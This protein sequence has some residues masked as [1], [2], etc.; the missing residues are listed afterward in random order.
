M[1]AKFIVE[2]INDVLKPKSKEEIENEI[3]N[4][5]A[6]DMLQYGFKLQDKSLIQRALDNGAKIPNERVLYR[7][8]DRGMFSEDELK[9]YF[10]DAFKL[11]SG[12]NVKN[13][14]P[15]QLFSAAVK[16][17]EPE[18]I[19]SALRKGATNVD[20]LNY[21]AL[22]IAI[23]KN[24]VSLLRMLMKNPKIDPRKGG[25]TE[26]MYPGFDNAPIR[27]AS[28]EGKIEIVKELLKDQRVDP[29]AGENWAL[30]EA[31]KHKRWN[32]VEELIKDKRVYNKLQGKEL[33]SVIRS[34]IKFI[35]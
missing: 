21:H 27:R 29:S 8:T 18:E 14:S 15:D 24:D 5:S 9:S 23:N 30:K 7:L 16:R 17:E 19:K 13:A 28:Q 25:R 22:M 4:L 32:V 11:K 1:K 6:H 35:K 26:M 20:F 3:N 34:L 2:G 33:Q 10:T 12:L 31:I